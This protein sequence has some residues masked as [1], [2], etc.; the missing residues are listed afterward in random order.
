[1]PLQI[2]G[3]DP[4]GVT[5]RKDDGSTVTIPHGIAQDMFADNSGAGFMGDRGAQGGPTF[6]MKGGYTVQPFQMSD[7]TM[8][9]VNPA[10]VDQG[11]IGADGSVMPA[12]AAP[13]AQP[14]AP[15]APPP[16]AQAQAQAAPPPQQIYGPPQSDQQPDAVSQPMGQTPGARQ[17]SQPPAPPGLAQAQAMAPRQRSGGGGGGGG[18]DSIEADLRKFGEQGAQA[19]QAQGD[20]KA[21]QIERST[22]ALLQAQRQ[23]MVATQQN[24]LEFKQRMAEADARSK[25]LAQEIQAI[26]QT[27][28]NPNEV[29]DNMSTAGKIATFSAL[30]MGGYAGAQHGTNAAVD[31]IKTMVDNS[32]KTQI[33]NLTNRREGV[34]QQQ[35]LIAADVAR[36]MDLHAATTKALAV[37]YDQAAKIVEL[38]GSKLDSQLAKATAA[39]TAAGLREKSQQA[40]ATYHASAMST[41]ATNYATSSAALTAKTRLQ[42]ETAVQI[43]GQQIGYAKDVME[44]GVK[45]EAAQAKAT[46]EQGKKTVLGVRFLPGT[47]Q[48]VQMPIGV[49]ANEKNADEAT[50]LSRHT[51]AA[52]VAMNEAYDTITKYRGAYGGPGATAA[53]QQMEQKLSFAKDRFRTALE[54]TRQLNPTELDAIVDKQFPPAQG[55]LNMQDPYERLLGAQESIVKN[56]NAQVGSLLKN[57]VLLAPIDRGRAAKPDFGTKEEQ[58]RSIAGRP[59]WI[60]PEMWTQMGG[61]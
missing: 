16:Q 33:A 37:G 15:D 43:A 52:Q 17:V 36:G 7:G 50:N 57:P 10:E 4:F 9:D 1:M 42:A 21:Q 3:S 25:A 6:P 23:L 49:G 31:Q 40:V 13:D 27:R 44:L 34:T 22:P 18:G 24:E 41:A 8:G 55:I 5:V 28:V 56:Y 20:I 12:P 19:A 47:G 48:A 39:E 61:Q 53:F 35:S 11:R 30:L 58:P 45:K 2:L 38:E 51:A 32:I 14:A 54:L 26:S 59:N 46:E 29:Y 60:S